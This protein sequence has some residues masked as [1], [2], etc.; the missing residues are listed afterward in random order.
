MDLAY[1]D[2]AALE[3]VNVLGGKMKNSV[4]RPRASRFIDNDITP[5]G[6]AVIWAGAGFFMQGAGYWAVER[7][8]DADTYALLAQAGYRG[9]LRDGV[10]LTA[11]LSYTDWFNARGYA[12]FPGDDPFGNSVDDQGKLLYDYDLLE[13]HVELGLPVAGRPLTLFAQYGANTA[14]DDDDTAWALG[15]TLGRASAPGSW[16]LGYAYHDMEK[17]AL[18]A[19]VVDSDLADGQTDIRGHAITGGYAVSRALR[20][21]FTYFRSELEVSTADRRDYDRL[22]LDVNF[23][24]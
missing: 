17:D 12:P 15:I 6:L 8:S 24:Y 16:E 10:D 21:N 20:L 23:R 1:F 19:Q 3:G 5:E 13:G 18:F 22:M 2:W 14:V 4:V 11:A 7:G 9:Q